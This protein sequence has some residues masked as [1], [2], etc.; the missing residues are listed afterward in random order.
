VASVAP[1]RGRHGRSRAQNSIKVYLSSG[2]AFQPDRACGTRDGG[3][4]AIVKWV[5]GDFNGDGKTDIGAVWE[6]NGANVLTVRASDGTKFSVAHWSE[7]NGGWI[8]T[9]AW[10]AAKLDP[11]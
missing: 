11:G 7:N 8:P 5:P 9:T 6:Y 4:P 2:S 3:I 1:N 10:C